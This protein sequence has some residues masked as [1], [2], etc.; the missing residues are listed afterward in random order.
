[1]DEAVR[2]RTESVR[3]EEAEG[4]VAATVLTVYPPG[5]PLVVPGEEIGGAVIGAVLENL[6]GG[7]RVLTSRGSFDGIVTV[8]AEED[9]R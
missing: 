7:G 3:L 1:M 2:Q 8:S 6:A 4:R 5:I 9:Q